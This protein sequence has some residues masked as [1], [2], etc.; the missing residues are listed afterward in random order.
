[1]VFECTLLFTEQPCIVCGNAGNIICSKCCKEEVFVNE[2]KTPFFCDA[3]SSKWHSHDKRRQHKPWAKE[4]QDFA[5]GT[6]QLLSVLC[7]ETSHYVCFTRITGSG[8]D[9]WVFFDSMA[10]RPGN[11]HMY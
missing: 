11:I 10:E 6:L 1:M 8:K 7:I 5:T 4:C 2:I 9:E 3:C